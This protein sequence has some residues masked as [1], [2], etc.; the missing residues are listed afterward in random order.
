MHI[1]QGTDGGEVKYPFSL[2]R[3]HVD[4]AMTHG[5]AEI[6]MPIGAM[7]RVALIKIHSEGDIREIVAGSC[8]IGGSQLYPDAELTKYR[9][10]N[11]CARRD[12]KGGNGFGSFVRSHQLFGYININPTT[13]V[14]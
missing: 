2:A 9:R 7:Q 10:M 1:Y 5:C 8:H 11:G 14:R 12:H 3:A 13:F 4:A 6:V